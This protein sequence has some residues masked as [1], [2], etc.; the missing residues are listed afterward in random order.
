MSDRQKCS[1][2]KKRTKRLLILRKRRDPGLGRIAASCGEAKVFWFFFS[3][4][5]VFLPVF[6]LLSFSAAATPCTSLRLTLRDA[7]VLSITGQ[8]VPAS[9]GLPALCS[10]KLVVSSNGNPGQSQIAIAVMLPEGS[11][12]TASAAAWNGRFLGTGN[13][14]FGGT[15]AT[16][17][18]IGALGPP[19]VA[20]GRTYVVANTDLGT[21]ILFH[22]TVQF[23]G[24][25]QGVALYPGQTPGGLHGDPAAIEDFGAGA[26]HLMT[27]AGRALT[28]LFYGVPAR[29]SFFH[30]CSTGGRQALTEAERFPADYD[31]IVA[32]SPAYDLTHLHDAAADLYEATHF[33]P[34]DAQGL[35][36]S[37]LTGEALALGHAAMLTQCAG[38]DG[39]LPTDDYLT[40]PSLCR[41]S[42][43]ALYC[44]GRPGDVPC[45]DPKGTSCTCLTFTQSVALNRL[46][47]GE[48]DSD[49]RILYPGYER[50]AE[51]NFTSAGLSGVPSLTEPL[52]DSTD[53]WVFGAE[54]DWTSLFPTTHALVGELATQIHAIDV[55]PVGSSSFAGV[56]NATSA[57]LRAFHA[58]G[59]KLI[60]YA[61]Y[62]DPRIPSAST[63]DY[64]NQALLDDPKAGEFINLYLAPGTWHCNGGPG[65][66]VFG[67]VSAIAPPAPASPTDDVVAALVRWREAGLRPGRIIA[68]KYANDDPKQGIA[69][70][71]P[72]CPYP[73]D[74]AYQLGDPHA[75]ASYICSH[76]PPVADQGFSPIYGPR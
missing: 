51:E 63:I 48:T 7:V 71:R 42:A 12:G 45:T 20:T 27:V 21:G 16:G 38:K 44:P 1:F 74:A 55:A 68:T 24:S 17:N 3:K 58:R 22:C 60:L 73:D 53:Y 4:K 33:G 18:M 19:Y 43:A 76:D 11:L 75:A 34:I 40:R 32:G 26:T 5:N 14:G 49:G 57:S 6:L 39:G 61:G 2:L 64:Y 50:S 30:G 23:C 31:G 8:D 13:G 62:A 56:L 25:A 47:D 65:A 46:W 54:F 10:V 29:A 15:V 36:N 72:L 35:P 67:N 28:R 59:G 70:Q 69:F 41:F 66:N 9:T 52:Y 37:T